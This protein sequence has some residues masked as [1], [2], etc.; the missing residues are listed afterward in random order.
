MLRYAGMLA[1]PLLFSMGLQAQERRGPEFDRARNVVSKTLDDLRHVARHEEFARGDHER[2]ERAMRELDDTRHD[3]D[4]GRLDRGRLDRSIEEVEHVARVG[5]VGPHE[6]E[7]L[8]E[9]A[10]ELRRLRDDWHWR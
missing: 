10:H 7:Q 1:V 8:M 5:M 3:L 6:R 2:Y 9:D 4:E